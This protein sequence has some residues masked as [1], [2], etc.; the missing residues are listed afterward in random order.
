MLKKYLFS[1]CASIFL[2]SAGL[3]PAHAVKEEILQTRAGPCTVKRDPW[4]QPVTATPNPDDGLTNWLTTLKY[5]FIKT[6]DR[7]KDRWG[8]YERGPI[9]D[10]VLVAEF[11]IG[12]RLI[13]FLEAHP[14][15][16]E[17]YFSGFNH[18][19]QRDKDNYYSTVQS[20]MGFIEEALRSTRYSYSKQLLACTL[21]QVEDPEKMALLLSHADYFFGGV[22][23]GFKEARSEERQ[24]SHYD[25][26]PGL[27]F[28]GRKL[29]DSSPDL[30]PDKFT[31]QLVSLDVPT[32]QT[33]AQ[34]LSNESVDQYK[35]DR[36]VNK[37]PN[38]LQEFVSLLAAVKRT[39][40]DD[41]ATSE[42]SSPPKAV[43]AEEEPTRPYTFGDFRLPEDQQDRFKTYFTTSELFENSSDEEVRSFILFFEQKRF[44]Q[45]PFRSA[46]P[47]DTLR[48]VFR[49]EALKKLPK[50]EVEARVYGILTDILSAPRCLVDV[51][52]LSE[53]LNTWAARTRIEELLKLLAHLKTIPSD[54]RLPFLKY[55]DENS[56]FVCATLDYDR[57]NPFIVEGILKG[58]LD[59]IMATI[60]V[61]KRHDGFFEWM[62]NLAA[63]SRGHHPT[64]ALLK[65]SPV[66]LENHVTSLE[67]HQSFIRGHGLAHDDGLIQGR[68]LAH[69]EGFM[70]P[71]MKFND[72]GRDTFV[73]TV[74]NFPH[75]LGKTDPK[76]RGQLLVKFVE[77]TP[78]SLE[79]LGVHSQT[80]FPSHMG[81]DECRIAII[82]TFLIHVNGQEDEDPFM[83]DYKKLFL[84]DEASS[85]E[86]SASPLNGIQ[87]AE[88]LKATH[89]LRSKKPATGAAVIGNFHKLSLFGIETPQQPS[90]VAR[91]GN[92][93]PIEIRFLF[94]TLGANKEAFFPEEA[95]PSERGDIF[96]RLMEMTP[97]D[98]KLLSETK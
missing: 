20:R 50:E 62:D 55:L 15:K 28:D 18:N 95:S 60:G 37:S 70:R 76:T 61:M 57:R 23:E 84:L 26:P 67:N 32:L 33:L 12:T 54:K 41:Q 19:R 81:S 7:K 35:N 52:N 9:Y 89:E 73:A 24:K 94:N 42:T 85:D 56:Q 53:R 88:V 25:I 86:G 83:G 27:T 75:L 2:L 79:R 51:M 96:G 69:D 1:T 93:L 66:D 82:N 90:F 71:F 59:N 68:T 39:V 34:I 40:Q 49:L 16:R 22:F 87:R 30:P 46:L 14:E 6:K 91:L 17:Q 10:L 64:T 74:Q 77:M 21:G 98:L 47:F 48:Q 5:S 29:F 63:Q 65:R 4:A 45:L 36:G 72:E 8:N 97:S 44:A 78:D 43:S 31:A 11:D 80:L 92:K 3:N 58:D 38:H 13:N